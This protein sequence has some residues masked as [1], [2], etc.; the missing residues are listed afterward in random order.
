[1][2][3]WSDLRLRKYH[4]AGETPLS[5]VQDRLADAVGIASSRMTVQ[6]KKS[7]RPSMRLST[8]LTMLFAL[9][10]ISSVAGAVYAPV[11]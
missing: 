11:C 1:V 4:A 7:V 3:W 8:L 6:V 2:R 10:F 5:E 9:S